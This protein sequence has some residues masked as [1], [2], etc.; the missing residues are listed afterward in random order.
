VYQEPGRF[1]DRH[2]VLIA[3]QDFKSSIGH[4]VTV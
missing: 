1:V 3:E 2:K 4:G